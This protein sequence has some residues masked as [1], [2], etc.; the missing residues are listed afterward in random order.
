MP[1]LMDFSTHL[2]K[3]GALLN[4]VFTTFGLPV[5]KRAA[6]IL[7]TYAL[8]F[9]IGGALALSQEIYMLVYR[10]AGLVV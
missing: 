4:P 2:F 3:D 10:S 8:Y 7:A 9:E 5:R 1:N 6:V